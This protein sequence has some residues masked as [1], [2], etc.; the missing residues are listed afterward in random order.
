VAV[1]V[2]V[3]AAM[4]RTR[5]PREIL[6][7]GLLAAP[8]VAPYARYYD[9]PVLLIPLLILL[10]DRLSERSGTVLLVVL[11]FLPYLQLVIMWRIKDMVRLPGRTFPEVTLFW[12]PM[13]LAVAWAASRPGRGAGGCQQ[14]M[15]QPD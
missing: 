14:S 2:V 13:L 15:A 5:P 10:G 3:R 4:D 7:L 1:A 8:F 12:V 6:A 11:V 9:F